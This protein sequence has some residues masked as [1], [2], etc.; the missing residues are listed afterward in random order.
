MSDAEATKWNGRLLQF[1]PEVAVSG[2]D[3]CKAPVYATAEGNADSL[4]GVE[5]RIR[6][7]DIGWLGERVR[8]TRISC[9]GTAWRALGGTVIW[10]D[11][12]H[13]LAPWD[14]V[15]FEI[16]AALPGNQVGE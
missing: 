13:G 5:Y 9:R 1:A 12:S 10:L 3:T 14:G 2:T 6:A 15:F 8:L 11:D 7:T 16:R 4:L